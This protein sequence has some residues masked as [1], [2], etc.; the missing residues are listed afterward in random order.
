M[1]KIT[2]HHPDGTATP[3]EVAEHTS[4]M[5]AALLNN[6]A[7]II[8]E[9]GGQAMCATCHVF[10]RSEIDL[11]PPSGDEDE[12]LDCTTEER[13]DCSRLSCQL[14]AG[15]DFDSIDVEIPVTQT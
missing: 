13:Q 11:A 12:M 4:V 10:V 15:R 2:Y 7:G 14:V 5:R 9:C 1:P 8:G 6:V 3:I